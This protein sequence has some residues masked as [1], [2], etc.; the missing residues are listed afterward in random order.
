MFTNLTSL[1]TSSILCLQLLHHLLRHQSNISSFI[2]LTPLLFHRMIA[3]LQ[4][5]HSQKNSRFSFTQYLSSHSFLLVRLDASSCGSFHRDH[6][7]GF[8]FF[9]R[10]LLSYLASSFHL[11]VHSTLTQRPI[12]MRIYTTFC[13]MT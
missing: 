1:L 9:P 10:R 6:P 2:I 8:V 7:C 4:H 13:F 5:F 3:L 11:P 12:A